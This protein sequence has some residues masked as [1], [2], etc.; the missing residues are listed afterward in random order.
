MGFF[1][2]C[3]PHKFHFSYKFAESGIPDGQWAGHI[4]PFCLHRRLKLEVQAG[5][6]K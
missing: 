6:A 5:Y 3:I 1:P 4:S 2:P